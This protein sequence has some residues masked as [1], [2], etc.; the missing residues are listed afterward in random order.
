MEKTRCGTAIRTGRRGNR[1]RLPGCTACAAQPR[2]RGALRLSPTPLHRPPVTP[3]RRA[4]QIRADENPRRC[5]RAYPRRWPRRRVCRDG[6]EGES[7]PQLG[8]NGRR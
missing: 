7:A 6:R 5:C 3:E 1:R 2:Q 4:S 8:A